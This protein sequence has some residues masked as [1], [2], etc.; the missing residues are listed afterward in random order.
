MK[1]I[2]LRKRVIL[3]GVIL[4]S[5]TFV[6][7]KILKLH[8]KNNPSTLLIYGWNDEQP[9]DNED[10][11]GCP[12]PNANGYWTRIVGECVFVPY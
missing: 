5:Q 9:S 4:K 12:P 10:P 11:T 8:K 6:T 1:K 3:D 7:K 2:L